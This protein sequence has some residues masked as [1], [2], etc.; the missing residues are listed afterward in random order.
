M[1][2]QLVSEGNLEGVVPRGIL[3]IPEVHLWD[4]H[5]TCC[6]HISRKEGMAFLRPLLPGPPR[7]QTFPS[8]FPIPG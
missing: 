7:A 1:G 4:Q 2:P 5:G 6:P 3:L 8:T